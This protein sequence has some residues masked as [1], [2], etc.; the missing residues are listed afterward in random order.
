MPEN[1]IPTV[2]INGETLSK[3]E[4]KKIPK[5]PHSLEILLGD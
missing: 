5:C 3:I 1:I 4:V 2:G